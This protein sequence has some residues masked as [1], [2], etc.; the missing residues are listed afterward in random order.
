MKKIALLLMTFM[1]AIHTFAWLPSLKYAR[2]MPM[3]AI[4]KTWKFQSWSGDKN[5]NPLHGCDTV[6]FP[7]T[8]CWAML[9][10]DERRAY[11]DDYN[12]RWAEVYL[13]DDDDRNG[14]KF[15]LC[16]V[17][18]EGVN[19]DNGWKLKDLHQNPSAGTT[20]LAKEV[21]RSYEDGS[22]FLYFVTYYSDAVR[23]FINGVKAKGH[24]VGVYFTTEWDDGTWD[25][26]NAYSRLDD[27]DVTFLQTPPT[28]TVQNVGWTVRNSKTSLEFTTSNVTNTPAYSLCVEEGN[29]KR[30]TIDMSTGTYKYYTPDNMSQ[31]KDKMHALCN[32]CI[33]ENNDGKMLLL[34]ILYQ[35]MDKIKR[36]F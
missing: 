23:Q 32:L 33:I 20:Y 29:G 4:D 11:W 18:P 9:S 24:H 22:G 27:K 1:F 14:P 28:P 12:L 3:F 31:Y 2:W 8:I 16:K 13:T 21:F 25:V 17:V 34:F 5:S 30:G 26:E 36:I 6:S 35:W 10:W 15:K 19:D 7:G